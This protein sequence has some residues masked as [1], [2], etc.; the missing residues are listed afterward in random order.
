MVIGI[1][2]DGPR[3]NNQKRMLSLRRNDIFYLHN[4]IQLVGNLV[5]TEM[6]N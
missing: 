4:I 5:W 1:L 2:F 3:L 6:R